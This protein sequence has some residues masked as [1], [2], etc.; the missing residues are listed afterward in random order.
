MPAGMVAVV[1]PSS[2]KNARPP[3]VCRSRIGVRIGGVMAGM[4]NS[5]TAVA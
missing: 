3:K 2:G 5:S 1:T 4:E